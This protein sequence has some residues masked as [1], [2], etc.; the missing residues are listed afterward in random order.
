MSP[1]PFLQQSPDQIGEYLLP[2]PKRLTLRSARL[3]LPG[4]PSVRLVPC[5]TDL[6]PSLSALKRGMAGFGLSLRDTTAETATI[7]LRVDAQLHVAAE[8]YRLSID[9]GGVKVTGR[10]PAGLFYGVRTLLQWMALQMPTTGAANGGAEGVRPRSLAGLAIE[11]WPDFSKRGVMLDISRDKVPTMET[12]RALIDLL[13][14]WKINQLQLYT[15]HTFAY[16]G[17]EVVWRDASPIFPEEARELDALCNDRF[18]DLVPNQNSFGHFHRWLVHPAYRPLAELP[19]GIQHPFSDVREPYGLCPVDPGTIEL[20]SDLYGQLLP[21]FRSGLFNVGL[22][23]TFDLGLGRSAEACREH[24]KEEVYVRFL[25]QVHALVRRHGRTMQFWGDIIIERPDLLPRLPSEHLIALEWGYEPDHPYDE[26]LGILQRAGVPFYVCPGTNSWNSL[27]GRLPE[28]LANIEKAA[29]SGRDHGAEGLLVTDWGD[30]G[31]LQ[32]LSTSFAGLMAGAAAAWN[33]D[34][35]IS[36]EKVADLLGRHVFPDET[37]SLGRAAVKLASAHRACGALPNNGTALFW[38]LISPGD[39]LTN[40]RYQGLSAGGVEESRRQIDEGLAL[41]AAAETSHADTALDARELSWAGR[42]LRL[43]CDLA[44]ARLAL[45]RSAPLA[46]V[47]RVTRQA[48]SR[49][50]EPLR[51][52]HEAIWLTRNRPGGRLDSLSRLGRLQ[53]ALSL[54]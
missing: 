54:H 48:L 36:E 5:G 31:H 23:E 19:E 2:R 33:V 17:H 52:E 10:D 51:I 37:G 9:D 11:D 45:D 47:A 39:M 43:A 41:L 49:Q 44:T 4:Q 18:I 28:A 6:T 27:T 20:L 13:A 38:L 3:L 35:C 34:R 40:P 21:N 46:A 15:E 14:G 12:L 16:R 50:L 1:D 25:Q 24:G 8:G 26:H 22:D 29:R 32:P 53:R 7:V 30:N 42:L